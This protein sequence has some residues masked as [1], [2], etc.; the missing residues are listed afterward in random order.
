MHTRLRAALLLIFAVG[1]AHGAPATDK[2]SY[3]GYVRLGPDQ[4][5]FQVC[6][7]PRTKR[8][9]LVGTIGTE[10]WK[11]VS[12]ILDAQP[13]CDGEAPCH[14]QEAYVELDGKLSAP[15]SYGPLGMYERQLDP[16]RFMS[17]SRVS[18]TECLQPPQ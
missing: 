9:W 14:L 1:C 2:P 13:G 11:Q 12:A 6:G 16:T 7:A 18:P 8:W 4:A 3:R 17:A 10:G 15:G 5:S